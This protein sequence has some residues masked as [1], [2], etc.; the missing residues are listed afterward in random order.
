MPVYNPNID[1]CAHCCYNGGRLILNTCK[2]YNDVI[3][4]L[5]NN[6]IYKDYPCKYIDLFTCYHIDYYME[7]VDESN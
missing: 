1:A 4:Y 2:L 6:D 3:V 5:K 7:E